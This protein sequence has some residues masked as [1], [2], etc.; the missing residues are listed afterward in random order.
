MNGLFLVTLLLL[1]PFTSNQTTV[2]YNPPTVITTMDLYYNHMINLD[3]K[4]FNES[5][6]RSTINLIKELYPSIKVDDNN[7]ELIK[8]QNLI[9][10]DT[11]ISYITEISGI[12]RDAITAS[13]IVETDWFRSSL[14]KQGNN[15]GG[16]K[17]RKGQ[18]FMDYN[19]IADG[20]CKFAK[21]PTL[22][23]AAEQ[24]AAIAT[25][26]RYIKQLNGN[27]AIDWINAWGKGGYW[28]KATTNGYD[29][30]RAILNIIQHGRK[31]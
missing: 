29:D 10:A 25:N 26:T 21:Y 6:T 5:P 4:A 18:P 24:W 14:F 22:K 1:L 11:L 2:A 30:R 7:E 12:D 15:I 31:T 13:L 16:V 20:I 28:S 17:A 9:V 19:N 3:V 23:E 8:Y 27:T